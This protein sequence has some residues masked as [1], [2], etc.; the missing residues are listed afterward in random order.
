[1]LNGDNCGH[2]CYHNTV[3]GG[4]LQDTPWRLKVLKGLVQ[5]SVTQVKLERKAGSRGGA[6]QAVPAPPRGGKPQSPRPPLPKPT[7]PSLSALGSKPT[8]PPSTVL[9]LCPKSCPPSQHLVT[10]VRVTHGRPAASHRPLSAPGRRWFGP[11]S[12]S[13]KIKSEM[14]PNY[15]HTI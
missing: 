2:S 11:E 4:H 13:T 1:M 10:L 3:M 5:G 15:F 12:C 8:R 7:D 6:G 14:I 9:G